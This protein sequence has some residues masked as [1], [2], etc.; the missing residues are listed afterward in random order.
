MSIVSLRWLRT[1]FLVAGLVVSLSAA[2]SAMQGSL[3]PTLSNSIHAAASTKGNVA[4]QLAVGALLF[5]LGLGFHTFLV[6]RREQ[7]SVPVHR[8]N[9]QTKS[10]E[11]PT[12]E[13][14]YWVLW[15]NVKI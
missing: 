1:C 3:I 13:R 9:K 4:G 5:L 15:M 12:A 14:K 8:G 6:S 11:K 7:R 2:G 10:G